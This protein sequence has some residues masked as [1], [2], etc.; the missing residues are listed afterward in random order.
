MK[1]CKAR[2]NIVL[3]Y[4]LGVICAT[5]NLSF[6][7]M[8][9]KN[10]SI[11]NPANTLQFA[12]KSNK[13]NIKSQGMEIDSKNQNSFNPLSFFSHN[14]EHSIVHSLETLNSNQY[15]NHIR[16]NANSIVFLNQLVQP[17]NIQLNF[18]MFFDTYNLQVGLYDS[19]SMQLLDSQ[20]ISSTS[21]TISFQNVLKPSYFGFNTH[22]NQSISIQDL[23]IISNSELKK[24]IETASSH[25]KTAIKHPSSNQESNKQTINFLTNEVLHSH[26]HALKE[27]KNHTRN[28][29]SLI[30]EQ[31]T[32]KNSLSD[33]QKPM[34]DELQFTHT[35]TDVQIL[36]NQSH[37]SPFLESKQ[38]YE[39][40][41]KKAYPERQFVQSE[42]F[43]SS[44][45]DDSHTSQSKIDSIINNK[46]VFEGNQLAN[47]QNIELAKS[48]GTLIV[49]KTPENA[50][51]PLLENQNITFKSD[52]QSSFAEANQTTQ[53]YCN[54]PVCSP[55][56]KYA[57]KN[58]D[59]LLRDKITLDLDPQ[60]INSISN[61][62]FLLTGSSIYKN[63]RVELYLERKSTVELLSSKLTDTHGKFYFL[64]NSNLVNKKN[65]RVFATIA[66]K[67]S[68][69]YSLH[70][71][72]TEPELQYTPHKFCG[73]QLSQSDLMCPL[74]QI[75]S[76]EFHLPETKYLEVLYNSE[77]T[78]AES[79]LGETLLVK[80]NQAY[81]DSMSNKSKH[82]MIY[83][84]R[85]K[86]N[87]ASISSPVVVEFKTYMPI[88]NPIV[89][90]LMIFLLFNVLALIFNKLYSNKFK[91]E[92]DQYAVASMDI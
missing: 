32:L 26:K 73:M 49:N 36:A 67:N 53:K 16:S 39:K 58:S 63:K 86:I 19:A 37:V 72:F 52:N 75:P 38:S 22:A 91:N 4:F 29:E 44:M 90:P 13:L 80:P 92:K 54:K 11:D 46:Q 62:N 70:T 56:D 61:P 47:K 45:D 71:S 57:D 64:I 69:K 74:G 12:L 55:I 30:N 59:N 68:V 66:D 77:V 8:Q 48:Q 7:S 28:S 14:Q 25:V 31:K 2:K 18:D 21:G 83:I 79:E 10:T 42:Q 35:D 17:G 27:I 76:F 40:K 33:Y 15:S 5:C 89:T 3:I 9:S 82:K 50:L 88:F 84:V 51:I 78:P 41:P 6:A 34:M 85:D 1:A 23:E 87:P 81:L 24:T 43:V 20:V 65:Y 60:K